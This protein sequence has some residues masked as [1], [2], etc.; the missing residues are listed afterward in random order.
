MYNMG[1]KLTEHVRN[2]ISYLYKQKRVKF[3]YLELF[4][5]KKIKFGLYFAENRHVLLRHCDVIR[6]PIFR[7]L[8]SLERGDHILS[9]GTKQLYFGRVN[10]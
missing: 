5:E 6:W 7:I 4:S 10:F 3:R 1:L 8:V 9:Y 2:T